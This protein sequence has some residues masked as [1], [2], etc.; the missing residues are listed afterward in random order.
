MSPLDAEVAR[1]RLHNELVLYPAR[2]CEAAIKQMLYCTRI[3]RRL[4]KRAGLGQLLAI[5]CDTCR[6]AGAQQHDIS[7]LGALA[8]QYFLCHTLEGCVFEHLKL[9]GHRRNVEAAHSDALSLNPRTA[10]ASQQELDKVLDEVACLFK[11]M[12]DHI[13]QIE[14]RMLAEISLYIQHRPGMP[15]ADGFMLIPA[16]PPQ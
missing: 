13:G 14:Q 4:Y 12:V 15:P 2:F 9:V 11:H 6:K 3:P 16:R 8:H 10:A 7:L 5:E 1:I